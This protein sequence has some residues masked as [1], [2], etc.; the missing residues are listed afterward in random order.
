MLPANS[1]RALVPMNPLLPGSGLMRISSSPLKPWYQPLWFNGR[2]IPRRIAIAYYS[3][4]FRGGGPDESTY[5]W[6]LRPC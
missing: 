2:L 1:S 4:D 3:E 6:Y 5:E